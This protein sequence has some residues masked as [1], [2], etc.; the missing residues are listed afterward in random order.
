MITFPFTGSS[1]ESYASQFTVSNQ[2]V[3]LIIGFLLARSLEL[4]LSGSVVQAVLVCAVGGDTLVSAT[5]PAV[6]F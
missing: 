4:E 5:T 3:F 1:V 2:H 6:S